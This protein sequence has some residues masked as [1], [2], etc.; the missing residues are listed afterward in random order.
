MMA[1]CVI[2][3]P[4][5]YTQPK[6]TPP[7]L[8]MLG[9]VPVIDEVIVRSVPN[10]VVFNVSVSSEDAG[11]SLL[12]YLLRNYQ[13]GK[14]RDRILDIAEVPPGTLDDEPDS[15]VIE[16]EWTIDD[17]LAPGCHRI[18]LF[19]THQFNIDYT[20]GPEVFKNPD[21]VAEAVWWANI[22]PKP[23]TANTLVDCPLAA[24]LQ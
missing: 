14:L 19:V 7:R 9:A 24:V 20:D 13:G 17:D 21:D 2:E 5:P 8:N 23:G 16:T 1:G 10:R 22:E 11:E 12:A 6:Q 3:D 15:R 18:T 4:P